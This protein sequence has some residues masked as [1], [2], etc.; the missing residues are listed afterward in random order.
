MFNYKKLIKDRRSRVKFL[1]HFHWVSDKV[2][3]KLQYRIKFGRKLNLKKPRRFTEKLQWY[4]LFYYNPLMPICA[5]KNKVRDYVKS[6]GLDYILNEQYAVYSS[7]DEIDFS[8]FPNKFVLKATVGSASQQ[9]YVCTDKSKIDEKEIREKVK[10]W[11]ELYPNNGKRKHVGREWPYDAVKTEIIAEKY[12]DSSACPDGLVS[13]KIFCFNGKPGFVYMIVDLKDGYFDADY[14]IY[15]PSF[16]RLPYNRV[17]EANLEP[18]ATK[19]QNWDEMIQIAETLSDGFPHVRIDLYNVN[20]KIIFGEM[21]FFNDSG[22]MKYNPDEFDF[23][24]GDMFE[25]PNKTKK[26]KN[27]RKIIK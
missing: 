12:I 8:L 4:K 5:G 22:Y 13:Y 7:P 23:V 17:C 24:A 25:L 21:T 3:I 9:V 2:M 1:Q 11:L 27:F 14:G 20:G 6:K 18:H 19:P 15:S 10:K 16:E 26:P